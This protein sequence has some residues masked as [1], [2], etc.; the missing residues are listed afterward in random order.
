LALEFSKQP[1][2]SGCFA[3]LKLWSRLRKSGQHIHQRSIPVDGDFVAGIAALV[4]DIR[5]GG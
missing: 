2:F 4:I 1:E 5:F 3:S